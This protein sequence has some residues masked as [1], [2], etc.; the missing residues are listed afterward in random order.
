[1]GGKNTPNVPAS[2]TT[3]Q[4]AD[5]NALTQIAQEQN[6]NAQ[7]LFNTTEPGIKTAEDFYGALSTGSPTAIQNAIAPA[8]QQINQATQG[9][10]TNI[11][12]NAP[13]GGEKNLA[14]EQAKAAAGAKIGDVATQGYLGSFNALGGLASQGISESQGAAGLGISGL[15]SGANVASTMGSQSLESQQL[16]LQQKG[17]TLGAVG[18][19]LGDATNLATG[20]IAS[21]WGDK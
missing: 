4:T 6:T 7:L 2:V 12:Q 18:G 1:M 17:Q 11:E 19:V 5:M 16:Q 14:I 20:G 10:I 13:N 15:N 3:A 8:A 21:S 9:A